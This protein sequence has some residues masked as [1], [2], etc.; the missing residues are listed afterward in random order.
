MDI[1]LCMGSSCFARGNSGLLDFLESFAANGNSLNIDLSGCRC[2]EQCL[3]GPNVFIN[4]VKHSHMT[5]EKMKQ[6]LNESAD[7]PA[8][9]S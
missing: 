2:E 6:L 5:V 1:E 4:G 8:P 9:P 7:N 3:D